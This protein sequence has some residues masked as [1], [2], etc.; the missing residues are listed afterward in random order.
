MTIKRDR[1]GYPIG[2]RWYCGG[3]RKQEYCHAG[4]SLRNA[5]VS[6][7]GKRRCRECQCARERERYRGR[8]AT[9]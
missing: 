7:D 6:A 2:G 3:Q 1:R 4:H 5:Y 9:A 8:K